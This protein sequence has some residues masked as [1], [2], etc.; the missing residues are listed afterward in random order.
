MGP[1][2]GRGVG[3]S[4]KSFLPVLAPMERY[5]F[6]NVEID[7]EQ[8]QLHLEANPRLT[9]VIAHGGVISWLPITLIL[10]KRLAECAPDRL[11]T[12][13]F[14]KAMWNVPG[15]SEMARWL[16]GSER[17]LNFDELLYALSA[18]DCDFFAFPESENSLYGN[19]GEIKPFRFHRFIE[20]SVKARMPMLLVAHKGSEHW[21]RSFRPL[22]VLRSLP[23]PIYS[24]LHLDK[25]QVMFE[26]ARQTLNL[27]LPFR[28]ISLRVRTELFQPDAYGRTFADDP[29]IKRLQLREEGAR[30]RARLQRLSDSI[31]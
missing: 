7:R 18:G 28:R 12:G 23:D 10:I 13:T 29:E 8:L 27:P 3:K 14:H 4:F 26:S 21:Y 31:P 2:L 16:S 25:Q 11:G 22:P 20:L 17:H 30:I 9:Y 5:P 1:I 6:Q 15:L 24:L 19:L